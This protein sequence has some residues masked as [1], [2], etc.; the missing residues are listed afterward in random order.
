MTLH[1]DIR[2]TQISLFCSYA[3]TFG[4][5][6]E[7]GIKMVQISNGRIKLEKRNCNILE[8]QVSII[9]VSECLL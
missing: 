2:D 3:A 7:R 6:I 1:W 8:K 9:G 5:T 4:I